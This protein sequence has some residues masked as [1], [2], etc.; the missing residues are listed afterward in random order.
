[1]PSIIASFDGEHEF[2]S[3]FY[4]APVVLDR[5]TFPTVEHAFQAAKTDDRVEK[6]AIRRAKT[7]GQAKR[8]GRKVT[9]IDYWGDVKDSMML[10][11]LRQKFCFEG[12]LALKLTQ[13]KDATLVEGNTRHDNYWGVCTCPKCRGEGANVLGQMLMTVRAENRSPIKTPIL[14]DHK[15]RR[16]LL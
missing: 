1:M 10:F 4:P 12:P 15:K 7:P 5:L 8:L 6:L 11:L 14:I 3:N 13:T 2:L 16:W 9:L